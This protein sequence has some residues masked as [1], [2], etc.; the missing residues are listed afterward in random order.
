[1]IWHSDDQSDLLNG[2]A[3]AETCHRYSCSSWTPYPTF[4]DWLHF[5]L[6]VLI[7]IDMRYLKENRNTYCMYRRWM[8]FSGPLTD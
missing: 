7:S 1:M 4:L 6:N 5:Y 2:N 3:P 8:A